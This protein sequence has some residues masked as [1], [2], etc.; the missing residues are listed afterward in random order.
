MVMSELSNR[1]LM[2]FMNLIL[3]VVCTT[4]LLKTSLLRRRAS[5]SPA[6]AV[7]AM[8][9]LMTLYMS[10]SNMLESWYDFCILTGVLFAFLG[11]SIMVLRKK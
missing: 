5:F 10:S 9:V 11:L 1:I 2:P 7:L 4:I 8:A 6:L 3:A